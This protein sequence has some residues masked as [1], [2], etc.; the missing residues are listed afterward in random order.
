MTCFGPDGSHHQRD[1]VVN[2]L[3]WAVTDFLLWR[4]SIGRRP[5]ETYKKWATAAKAHDTPF[6]AYHFVYTTDRHPADLQA[7]TL[8]A[9]VGDTSIPVMLDWEADGTQQPSFDDVTRVAH[10][11][12]EVGY[13][14]PLLYTG[15]WWWSLKGKPTLAGHGFDLANAAYGNQKPTDTWEAEPRYAALGGD[16][17]KRWAGYG[18]LTPVMWQFSSRVRFGNAY[19]DC[20]AIREP[21]NLERWFK[22]WTPS[23]LTP[24][25]PPAPPITSPIVSED[26]MIVAKTTDGGHYASFGYRTGAMHIGTKITIDGAFVSGVALDASAGYPL[27]RVAAGSWPASVAKVTKAQAFAILGEPI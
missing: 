20:N 3:D 18:G 26:I 10:A 11:I 25:P 16:S 15:A 21:A 8:H 5:D 19:M 17:S 23:T 13:R 22:H 12:R 6:C 4:A 9:T 27:R 7:E 24:V 1:L 14:V 2:E